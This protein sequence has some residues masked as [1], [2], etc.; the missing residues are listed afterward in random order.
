M[1]LRNFLESSKVK[2]VRTIA[3]GYGFY[4]SLF[5]SR[6]AGLLLF[7]DGLGSWWYY[8]E[9]PLIEQKPR[10]GRALLGA[11]F[12]FAPSVSLISVI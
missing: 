8:R 10:A 1:K 9:Q 7:V 11:L 6:F 2:I 3:Y 12:M 5:N 4:L